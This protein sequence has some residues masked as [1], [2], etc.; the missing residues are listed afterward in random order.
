MLGLTIHI[1]CRPRPAL[2]SPL[3]CSAAVP[4]AAAIP[5][6]ISGPIATRVTS[7]CCLPICVVYAVFLIANGVPQTLAASVDAHHAGSVKQT[8]ALGPS[9]P[10]SDQ[11]VG[12]PMAAAF[13][14]AN[15]AHPFEIQC[16]DQPR[17]DA[18][19][20]RH[21]L[22]PDLTFGQGGRQHP[23][24]LGHPCGH[25]HLFLAGVTG[26]LLAGSRGQPDPPHLAWPAVIWRARKCASASPLRPA[27]SRSSPPRQAAVRSMRCMTASPHW[28]A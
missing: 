11:D 25:A 18:V 2:R 8:L 15:S 13:F 17:P 26:H 28:A 20:L 23:S 4:A 16:A 27:V 14:N 5:S 9:P 12:A 1:S 22:R 21:R 6:A 10:G 24:G 19:D 7:I 3:R